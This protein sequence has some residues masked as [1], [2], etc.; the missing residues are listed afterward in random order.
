MDYTW[1]AQVKADAKINETTDDALLATKISEASRAIDRLVTGQEDAVDYF[2]LATVSDEILNSNRNPI[3]SQTGL[4][5][6]YPHKA[7][8]KSVSAV[9]VRATPLDAWQA[10]NTQYCDIM[11]G[12]TV[13]VY[14]G[15]FDP[16]AIQVKVSYSGGL[17]TVTSTTSGTPPVTTVTNTLPMDLVE[18]ATLLTIRLYR[19]AMGGMSD[20]I[21][22]AELGT[23]LY[24][25]A[26]P[27]R[28]EMFISAYTRIFPW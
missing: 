24:S 3:V 21:G 9:W 2:A 4:L 13:R 11:R 22:I 14:G 10:V 16:D 20:A 26:L 7:I 18:L 1:L 27:V 28:A 25:K 17:G 5:D 15:S 8:V 19:E 12:R 23:I 6:F